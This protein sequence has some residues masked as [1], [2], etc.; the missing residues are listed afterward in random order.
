MQIYTYELDS[1]LWNNMRIYVKW[2]L[3]EI[4]SHLG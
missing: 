1:I 2:L 4:K 3:N